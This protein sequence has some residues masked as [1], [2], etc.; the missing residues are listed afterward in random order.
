MRVCRDNWARFGPCG[1]SEE[2]SPRA[3]ARGWIFISGVWWWL[4]CP[5][6]CLCASRWPV[7][8]WPCTL[9]RS[10]R[11]MSVSVSRIGI[12]RSLDRS[13]DQSQFPGQFLDQSIC[14]CRCL[15]K[16]QHPP[17]RSHFCRKILRLVDLFSISSF[18]PLNLS[19]A[20]VHRP[21]HEV[22]TPFILR[23]IVPRGFSPRASNGR[24]STRSSD[25]NPRT[26]RGISRGWASEKSRPRKRARGCGGAW[27]RRPRKW[28]QK[29]GRRTD[30][31]PGFL[32]R[33]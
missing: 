17:T 32:E 14:V 15:Y 25:T 4:T 23:A 21:V 11:A 6:V 5:C 8:L 31:R 24:S 10:R 3:F 1:A 18:H 27:W 29:G 30:D 12:G 2:P 9:D 16:E 19:R 20:H 22:A 28:D 26:R 7:T 13:I 33:S